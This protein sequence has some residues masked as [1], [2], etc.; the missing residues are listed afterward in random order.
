VLPPG[1]LGKIAGVPF[2]SDAAIEG[3]RHRTG[4]AEL[5]SPSCPSASQI[6]HT[7]S[8]YGVG[9]APAYAP[10]KLYLAGPFQGRPLSLVAINSAI[11]GPFDLGTVVIRSAIDVDQ[12]TARVSLDAAN[13]D[14]IPHIFAGIPLHLRDIRVYLDRP[15]FMVNPTSCAPFQVSS[16]LTGSRAPFLNPKDTLA[17]SAVP[18][19]ASGCPERGFAPRFGLTLSGASKRGTYP[20]LRAVF[21]PR[22]GDANLAAAAV[23]LPPSLFLAQE[24]IAAICTR[25]QMA[26]DACPP[27]A[28]VGSAVAQTP[29]LSESM[30]GPVYLRSSDHVLPDLVAVLRGRGVRIL[31][32]GRVDSYRGGIRS[33]FEGLPDAPLSQFSMTIFGG[34]KKGILVNAENLCRSAQVVNGRFVSQSNR[35]AVLKPKISVRCAKKRARA[36]GRGK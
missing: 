23:T 26:A 28:A 36:K 15:D 12:R 10:G 5:L 4:T 21:T 11:V 2:C 13:S 29:L 17:S 30:E 34:K 35:S 33:T 31:V 18:F 25:V 27:A 24:H 8:G 1:L 16:I 6:G 3:A 14:P 19:Q 20:R 22:P 9:L 32:E 7:V